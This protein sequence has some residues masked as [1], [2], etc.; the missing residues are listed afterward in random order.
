[1][2]GVSGILLAAGSSS[3]RSLDAISD[4]VAALRHRGPDASEVFVDEAAG[5]AL[6]HRRLAILDLSPAGIQPMHSPSG[7][8]VV[9]YNGEI[10]NHL[11]MRKALEDDGAAPAWRGHSDTETL[12]AF[13]EAR[14]VT[15]TLQRAAGMFALALWDRKERR[16]TL[17]R[18]R[19][20][21]KPLYYGRAG[22]ALVFASELKALRALPGFDRTIDPQAVAAYFQQAYVPAPLCIYKAARK[23]PPGHSI[24]FEASDRTLEARPVP[25]WS[26][27]DTIAAGR[28][29]RRQPPPSLEATETL[30]TE[31]IASQTLSDVPLGAF[32]SGGIDSSLVTAL[33]QK[34]ATQAVRTFSIG[35]EDSHFNEAPI[36]AAVAK[37]LGTSHTEMI[38]REQDALDLIPSLPT[39]Y[40]EPFA[41]SSQIPTALLARMARAHVTVALSGDGGDEIFG[42]YNRYLFAPALY[43]KV[44]ALPRPARKALAATLRTVARADGAGA[45]AMHALVKRLGLPRTLVDRLAHLSS[46]V[47][48]ADSLADVFESTASIWPPGENPAFET[49]R[50]DRSPWSDARLADLTAAE[51]MMAIDTLTYLPDDIMVKVDRATMASSLESRAP[52]LDVRVVE[53]AWRLPIGAKIEGRTG[54]SILR[55]ILAPHVPSDL[56]ERPK[57]GFSI[58]IDRWLSGELRDW[59]ETLLA[60]AALEATGFARPDEITKV[61]RA[62]LDGRGKHGAKLWAALMLQAWAKDA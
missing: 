54:K 4:M 52:F 61:W 59:A 19:I 34:G 36:A 13:I 2:C 49:W 39:I 32:L 44:S 24:T 28:E 1:M 3:S 38:V 16:L 35:F 42:G 15:A 8:F 26:L 46:I 11:E 57:Q 30:L 27:V 40:D 50:S 29:A 18:D 25:Y 37:H 58:P 17:A 55:R 21:E 60:P 20:G 43:A 41:D 6:G 23:L 22:D 14:G 47:G 5:L 7:R 31:V 51:K 12:L 62:H 33:M 10:Y 53:H 45:Q 48:G 9:V 56:F